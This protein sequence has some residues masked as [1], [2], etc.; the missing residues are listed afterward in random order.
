VAGL[1]EVR[2]AARVL[3]RVAEEATSR[4]GTPPGGPR[5]GL[6][7]V[8][9]GWGAWVSAFRSGPL[10]WAEDL[11]H[12]IVR[13]GSRAGITVI[14]SGGRELVTA[15]FFAGLPNRIFFPL[16]STDEGRLA[17]PRLPALEPVPGRVA[18]FGAF[19]PT[20]LATGHAAQLFEPAA[21]GGRHATGGAV[22]TRPFRVDALPGLVTVD[23]VLAQRGSSGPGQ[24]IP[25]PAA[26]P[27]ALPGTADVPV[28][29]AALV[30]GVGG[31]ELRPQQIQLPPGGVLAVLGGPG[32]GKSTLL[33]ALPGMNPVCAWLAPRPGTDAGQYWSGLHASALAGTLDRSA[34]AL[35]DDADLLSPEANRALAALNSLGWRVIL[36]AGFGPAFGQR[37]DLAATV[38]GQGRAVLIRP[39]GLMDSEPF[40]V[41]FDPERS[42]PPGRAVVI[43]DGRATPVQLAA[44]RPAVR[45]DSLRPNDGAE[46]I[47]P[48]RH[49]AKDGPLQGGRGSGC[50]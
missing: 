17:W 19:V 2:R 6:V 29:A 39:R 21:A 3:R 47:S 50:P 36:T 46:R 49:A 18:V 5:P 37:V 16:G 15:R 38:R 1:Q 35:A 24:R 34:I 8:L 31:D 26:S 32:S 30:L 43:S 45:P 12:D 7:L 10:A 22:S 41:R 27:G 9:S 33:A 44:P 11:V 20:P 42:P 23:E 14:V 48:G 4:L 28:P 40:G 25:A 13:D